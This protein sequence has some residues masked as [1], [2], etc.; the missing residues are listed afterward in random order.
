MGGEKEG[1]EDTAMVLES[2]SAHIQED[3]SKSGFK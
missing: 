3:T 1:G 2:N